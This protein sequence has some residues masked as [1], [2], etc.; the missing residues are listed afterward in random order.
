[1]QGRNKRDA[2]QTAAAAV[3]ETLM[4]PEHG[5]TVMDLIGGG[6]K[7]DTPGAGPGHRSQQGARRGAE[8]RAGVSTISA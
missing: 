1:M 4:G 5:L 7:A 2:R 6:S 3:L 8:A